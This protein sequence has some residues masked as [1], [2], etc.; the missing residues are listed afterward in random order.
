MFKESLTT[1]PHEISFQLRTI[2][3]LGAVNTAS[4]HIKLRDE[5]R[6]DEAAVA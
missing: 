3:L 6:A 4:I 5:E 1:S 2:N